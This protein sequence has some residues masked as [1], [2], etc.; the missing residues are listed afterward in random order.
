VFRL[1]GMGFEFDHDVTFQPGVVEEQVDE[2]LIS[3]NLQPEL[4]SD[5]GETRTQFEQKAGDVADEGVFDVA[6]M[7]LVRKME[8]GA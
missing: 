4:A 1:E 6:L 5:E 8:M 3:G 2:E 7:G